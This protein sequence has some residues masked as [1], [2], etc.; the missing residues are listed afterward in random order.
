MP[1]I[2]RG[3][4]AAGRFTKQNS[5]SEL[6]AGG[7]FQSFNFYSDTFAPGQGLVDDNELGAGR[8]NE[9]DP[10]QQAEDLPNPTG[11]ITVALDRNQIGYWLTSMFGAPT[12][13]GAG[14]YTHEWTSAVLEPQLLGLELPLSN[15]IFR[16]VD[17]LAV[18]Q[19]SFS[20]APEPGYRSVT[21]DTVVRSVRSR[22]AALSASVE[23]APVRDKARGGKI[24]I[25]VNDTL[26]GNVLGGQAQIGNGAFGERYAD[27]DE[28]FSAIEIGT[29]SFSV[30]PQI[31]VRSGALTMLQLF[32]GKTPFTLE[33]IFA[34]GANSLSIKASN[35]VAAPVIPSPQNVGGLEVTPQ[36]MGSQ[37]A[38]APM[39]TITLVNDVESY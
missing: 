16:I 24:Q 30:S 33:L 12:S 34:E 3:A 19:M 1:R 35:M 38:D 28:Y 6:A 18:S 13:D 39:L 5:V 29:P 31:R 37:T 2:L 14:P 25:K 4:G 27:G 21:L 10:T 36:F 26:F 15:E 17:A 23:A 32:D 7:T 8:H 9:V 20:L 11:Q 22:N